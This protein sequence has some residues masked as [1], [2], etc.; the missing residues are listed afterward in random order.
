MSP[1]GIITLQKSLF[2][3]FLRQFKFVFCSKG[4]EAIQ[5]NKNHQYFLMLFLLIKITIIF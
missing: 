2:L 4:I 1:D 3:D 5:T